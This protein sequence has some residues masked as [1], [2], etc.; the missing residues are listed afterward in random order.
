MVT[1]YVVTFFCLFEIRDILRTAVLVPILIDLLVDFFRL[2]SFISILKS[3]AMSGIE[4]AVSVFL[5]FVFPSFQ[6]MYLVKLTAMSGI[7]RKFLATMV[8]V[9]THR[10]T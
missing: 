7:S 2:S 1:V 6:N 4:R 9:L 5:C 10:V 3:T 8:R